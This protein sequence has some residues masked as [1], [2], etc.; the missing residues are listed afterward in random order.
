VAAAEEAAEEVEAQ[1]NTG[2][3]EG[4]EEE[5]RQAWGTA[6]DRATE[7]E[8][9]QEKAAREEAKEVGEWEVAGVVVVVEV[10]LWFPTT[11]D[12]ILKWEW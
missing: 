1:G 6:P 2:R 7:A 12:G 9:G 10:F 3:G 11:L 8:W 5:G 4:E